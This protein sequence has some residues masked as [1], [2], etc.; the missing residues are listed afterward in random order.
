MFDILAA[1]KITLKDYRSMQLIRMQ[2][3]IILFWQGLTL[4][5]MRQRMIGALI[6]R[7]VTLHGP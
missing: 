5:S 3:Q 7:D 4:V 2:M 1:A 6:V